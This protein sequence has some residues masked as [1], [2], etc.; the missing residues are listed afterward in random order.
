V[1]DPHPATVGDRLIDALL[2]AGVDHVFGIPGDYTLQLN[3]RVEERMQFVG[4]LDEQGAGFAADAYARLRGLGCVMVTWGVGGLKLVNSTAQAW[5]ES[6]PV[7]VVSGAPGIAERADDPLLHH[8][9]KGFDTQRRVMEQVTALT[10]ELDDPATAPE[11][12][13][14]AIATAIRRQKPVYIEIPRDVVSM[15]APPLPV[16]PPERPA[17]PALVADAVADAISVIRAASRP[18]IIAGIQV[19]RLGLQAE[20]D[21]LA[22]A[23]GFP[24]AES[25]LGKSAVGSHHDWCIGVYAGALSTDAVRERVESSD[26]VLVL[27]ARL[28]DLNTGMFTVNVSQSQSI[29]AHPEALTVHRRS[30]P[31]VGLRELMHA[32]TAEFPESS[33]PVDH[34]AP[35]PKATFNPTPGSPL[36]IASAFSAMR[37]HLGVGQTVLADPG[38][39]LFGSTMLDTEES[40]FIASGF[41]ASLGFAVPGALGAGLARPD[42]RPVVIVGDGAFQ[43]T[44]ME[45]A[46]TARWGVH[47]VVIVLNNDGYGTERPMLEGGFNDIPALRYAALPQYLGFGVGVRAETEDAFDMALRDALA[48]TSQLRVIEAIIPRHDVS[49]VLTRLTDALGKRARNDTE[50]PQA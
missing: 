45:I 49:P 33:S 4:T 10:V 34:P 23:T 46:A 35:Q 12:I 11:R 24:V 25:L 19:A 29:L 14:L 41:Y 5:A 36:G 20:L 18:V 48:D 8:R 7:V 47:P 15:P 50:H 22:R 26:C 43:M 42:R 13:A 17:D 16:I 32:L 44:G 6:S 38:D 27:G 39:A 28:T 31:G 40:G 9:V 30:Y 3:K 1:V 21:A 37:H 2:A